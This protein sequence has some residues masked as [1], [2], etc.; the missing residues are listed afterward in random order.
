[1]IRPDLTTLRLFL[2]VYNLGNISKASEREHIAP[3]AISKRIQAF[4]TEVGTPLFYRHA[5]G[6]LP[7]PAGKALAGHAQ[8][9]FDDLNRMAADL[10][11]Y[12]VDE[13]GEVRV[14]AHS[15]AVI[16]YL[17][18]Q[19]ES[20]RRLH[21]GVQVLLREE[22]SA[23]VLQSL[24]DGLADLGILD[25]TV[26]IPQQLQIFPYMKDTLVALFPADHPL[27]KRETIDFA[28][29]RD[30]DHV[31]LEAGSSLQTLVARAAESDG[32][33]L[34]TRLEVRTFE[35]AIRMVE[36]GLGVAVIP[37][38]VVRLH[39]DNTRVRIVMLSDQWAVRDLVLCVKDAHL[40]TVSARLM[41]RHLCPTAAI[42]P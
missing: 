16:Q 17:P 34:K 32:F 9:L 28:E 18:A 31:S 7:T 8:T 13:R 10:S 14:H 12:A 30:S 42:D 27:A 26:Q 20:F 23:D 37:L 24:V 25:G 35:S 3:S 1:V 36:R 29:I 33:E 21:A 5:R 19:I 39:A 41:L 4:E 2:A 40:L 15:S 22:T 11:S 6:V 38:Q